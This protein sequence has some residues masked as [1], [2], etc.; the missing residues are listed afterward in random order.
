[1]KFSFGAPERGKVF[2]ATGAI[3][4]S[5]S[6]TELGRRPKIQI[7]RGS[8]LQ[9]TRQRPESEEEEEP[10][11]EEE[12]R[13]PEKVMKVE[14]TVVLASPGLR[15]ASARRSST[16]PCQLR[17]A[18]EIL[19]G[20]RGGASDP[21]ASTSTLSDDE[22]LDDDDEDDTEEGAFRPHG[23]K[24]VRQKRT[25]SAPDAILLAEFCQS[26]D[27]TESDYFPTDT[28]FLRALHLREFVIRFMSFAPLFK[29][30][31]GL[32]ALQSLDD[33]SSFWSVDNGQVQTVILAGLLEI[34][35]GGEDLESNE[36]AKEWLSPMAEG[37]LEPV[38][39]EETVV[40][41]VEVPI[42][43]TQRPEDVPWEATLK[44]ARVQEFDF[45]QGKYGE[46]KS[47]LKFGN[48]GDILMEDRMGLMDMVMY[49]T[50]QSKRIRASLSEVSPSFHVVFTLLSADHDESCR[51]FMQLVQVI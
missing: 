20:R 48:A 12:E 2:F 37:Q 35:W 14:E 36:G 10:E 44:L 19:Q 22:E 13:E 49:F 1:V 30:T 6:N 26:N 3:C 39:L 16:K 18:I 21:V 45:K 8:S 27:E 11:E 50:L 51:H 28:D 33:I 43:E 5:K 15:S 31:Q 46:N 23:A 40:E 41:V 4:D 7:N 32:E 9:I 29:S 17:R 47:V 42:F 38:D 24:K 25:I 34:L